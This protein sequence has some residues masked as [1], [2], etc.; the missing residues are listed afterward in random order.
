MEKF[1][2]RAYGTDEYINLTWSRMANVTGYNVY[3]KQRGKWQE[4]LN[5]RG[6]SAKISNARAGV[7]YIFKVASYVFQNNKIYLTAESDPVTIV[8]VA[9]PANVYASPRG[10]GVTVFFEGVEKCDGYKISIR[11]CGGESCGSSKLEPSTLPAPENQAENSQDTAWTESSRAV[12]PDP[13]DARIIY[14]G[15]SPTAV[16]GLDPGVMYEFRVCAFMLKHGTEYSGKWSESARAAAN[17]RDYCLAEDFIRLGT[18][19]KFTLRLVRTEDLDADTDG[20]NEGTAPAADAGTLKWSSS[21]ADVAEVDENGVV[22]GGDDGFAVVVCRT[23]DGGRYSAYVSV[24]RTEEKS[25]Y[26]ITPGR[27]IRQSDAYSKAKI[28]ATI[29]LT[30]DIVCTA[31][32]QVAAYRSGLVNSAVPHHDDETD[33]DTDASVK[34][35]HD[36]TGCFARIKDILAESDFAVGGFCSTLSPDIPYANELPLIEDRVNANVPASFLDA[37]KYA[38]FDYLVPGFFDD[39]N[40]PEDACEYTLDNISKY[41]IG[42]F[43]PDYACDYAGL[44]NDFYAAVCGIKVAFMY[45]DAVV[46]PPEILRECAEKAVVKA[47]DNGVSFIIAIARLGIPGSAYVHPEAERAARILAESGADY[48]VG[49]GNYLLSRYDRINVGGREVPVFYSLGGLYSAANEM[50]GN[51]RGAILQIKLVKEFKEGG[52]SCGSSLLEPSTLSESE[53][54]RISDECYIP[55]ATFNEFHNVKYLITP[56]IPEVMDNLNPPAF[57]TVKDA[58]RAAVGSK[59]SV[60]GEHNNYADKTVRLCGSNLLSR[61]FE[62]IKGVALDDEALFISVLTLFSAGDASL[63]GKSYSNKGVQHDVAKDMN[64]H[65]T[66]HP[67]DY[68]VLDMFATAVTALLEL[69]GY[70]YTSTAAVKKTAFYGKNSDKFKIIEP[71]FE[72][73]LWQPMMDNFITNL[74]SHYDPSH[75]VLVQATPYGFYAVKDQIRVAPEKRALTNFIKRLESYFLYQVRC[76]VIDISK[77]Y[78]GDTISYKLV[79][80]VTYDTYFFQQARKIFDEILSGSGQMLYDGYQDPDIWLR[81]YL[82][83]YDSINI[84]GYAD[85]LLNPNFAADVIAKKSCK[86]FI[87]IYYDKFVEVKKYEY[88]TLEGVLENY[89]GKQGLFR[90]GIAAIKSIQD[91]TFAEDDLNFGVVFD[92]EFNIIDELVVLLSQKIKEYSLSRSAIVTRGTARFYFDAVRYYFKTY[93]LRTTADA[94][95]NY[96]RVNHPVKVDIWGSNVTAHSLKTCGKITVS[97]LIY[98]SP[99]IYT[100]DAPVDI[101]EK[102]LESYLASNK[103]AYVQNVKDLLYRKTPEIIEKSTAD[104]IV[105][106]FFDLAMQMSEYGG[107]KFVSDNFLRKTALYKHIKKS[108]TEFSLYQNYDRDEAFAAIDKM[109]DLLTRKYGENIILNRIELKSEYLTLDGTM[110]KFDAKDE[111]IKKTDAIIKECEQYFAQGSDS[112][113]SFSSDG[114]LLKIFIPVKYGPF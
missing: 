55:T 97:N 113:S 43:T 74:L 54:I 85:K 111:F 28:E 79:N 18:G 73:E 59:I 53:K 56:V 11:E 33:E 21:D 89:C 95:T 105:L 40:L 31:A 10:G 80:S 75:I 48:V 76:C 82:F 22:T 8:P 19:D 66:E 37:V 109:T 1:E 112:T 2:L 58:I 34:G 47:R 41:K 84:M 52:E 103:P 57:M 9:V 68:F 16:P 44:Y 6:T 93:D 5:V 99:F 106:D 36:F 12:P 88:L 46:C 91:G 100:F 25:Y 98:R 78:F 32:Q 62:K 64:A 42:V 70:R 50:R 45:F 24:N 26:G 71:Y 94:I 13:N 72:D 23:D 87:K 65:M 39:E 102:T 67:T 104:W 29:M 51:R 108:T 20:V 14:V 63:A 30:G 101:P 107:A 38:G 96:G 35:H 110:K 7:S 90:E 114:N 77:N 15:K 92:Y 17:V 61:I 83:Y 4:M 69:D 27:Y 49:R 86:E 81:R 3:V 60:Y